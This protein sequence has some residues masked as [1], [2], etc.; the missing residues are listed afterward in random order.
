MKIC[1]FTKHEIDWGSSRERI[2]VHL[3]H[4]KREGHSYR[5]IYCIPNE[6]SQAW[7]G[8][9]KRFPLFNAAYS[10]WRNRILKHL[11]LIQIIMSADR[12]DRILVQKVNLL[13]P[14]V[15][16]LR[17][18]NKN[19][20]FDF[21]D[22]CFWDLESVRRKK[23]GFAKRIRFWRRGLQHP[24]VLRSYNRIIAGNR[25]L[26]DLAAAVVD[27]DRIAVIP[28]PIDCGL[29]FPVEKEDRGGAVIVG[30]AGSGENHLRHLELLVEPLKELIKRYDM[31]FKL[32]G[33]MRSDR[34]RNLFAFLGSR[35]IPVDWVDAKE[36]PEMIRSFDIGV[37]PLRDDDEARGK[38]GFK[39][40]QYMATGIPVVISPVGVNKEMVRDGVNGF[41]AGSPDEWIKKI[42]SLIEDKGM[43][44]DFGR[45]GR[46]T[47]EKGY[48]LDG[49]S[50]KFMEIIERA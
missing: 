10:F 37:M 47:V 24:S 11:K 9:R 17:S 7:I 45:R 39:V 49:A 20:I 18:R 34:I 31:N 33:A 27:K 36:L 32:V 35:F 30:W 26:A 8:G 38:C 15:R 40:L 6:L 2:G 1:F 22:Q 4:I 48:S 25:Y 12:Y 23:A 5:V 50:K 13:A 21:D 42:S 19:I 44:R 46:Q 16:V 29:Y 28:T 41:L 3:D 14:L 43:R